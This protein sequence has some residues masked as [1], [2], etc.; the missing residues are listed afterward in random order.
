MEPLEP[1]FGLMHLRQLRT[2]FTPDVDGV[3][4]FGLGVAG[5]A[6]LLIDDQLVVANEDNQVPGMLFVRLQNFC[7][8]HS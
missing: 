7:D 2:V 5:Q 1:D 3:W 8:A 6:K 4:E